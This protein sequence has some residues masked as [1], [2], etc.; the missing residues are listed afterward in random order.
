MWFKNLKVFRLSEHWVNHLEDLDPALKADAFAPADDMSATSVGWVPPRE[1]DER[2]A[3]SVNG[4]YLLKFRLEKKLLPATVINQTVKARAQL[5]EEEQGWPPGRKQLKDLKQVVTDEL[6]PRAF[7]IARD[8]AIWID[9]VNR[10]LVIDSAAASQS[11]EVLS[12]L[13]RSLHPYPV[14]P[15]KLTHSPTAMMTDW[16]LQAE[17]PDGLSLDDDSQWQAGGDVASSIRYVRHELPAETI[18]EHIEAG[19]QCTRLAM[20]WQDRI[21]FVLSDTADIK[22]VTPLDIVQER[23][24]EGG[25]QT[26]AEKF[27]SDFALMSAELAQLLADLMHVLGENS[28]TEHA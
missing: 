11:D 22:K 18:K 4:Q 14:E 5:L 2:F 21:S 7:S 9:P 24:N 15:L 26:P 28:E 19:Y 27:E 20:T 6:L 16:M 10:W 1:D 8:V 17:A 25:P 23:A 12:A 13:G 3:V